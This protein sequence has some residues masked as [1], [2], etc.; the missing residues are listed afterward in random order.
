MFASVLAGERPAASGPTEGASSVARG[1]A[2]LSGRADSR[3]R[4]RRARARQRT[5]S[6]ATD[7][8]PESLAGAAANAIA[9]AASRARREDGSVRRLRHAGL[10]P[11]GNHCRAS[12]LPRGGGA[13]GRLAHG[14]AASHRT[15]RGGGARDAGA[16][17]RRRPRRRKAALCAL[18]QRRRRHPRRPDGDAAHRPPVPRRQ[19]RLQGH[20]HRAP[21]GDDPEALRHRADA[22]ARPARAPG[23][24]GSARCRAPRAVA[25]GIDVHDRRGGDDR[26]HR[27]LRD[28]VGLYRRGRLRDLGRRR[29]RR[30]ARA[31]PARRAGGQARRSRRTRHLAPRS[32][33]VPLR[34]H[35][36]DGDHADRSGARVGDPEGTPGRQR[37]GG[38]PGATTIVHQLAEA[39]RA[40]A[41]FSSSARRCAKARRSSATPE[42]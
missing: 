9:R 39:P 31:R 3:S 16:G 36:I 13:V 24:R 15:R 28:A 35:D 40:S 11:R 19:R 41:S 23:T 32:G 26:R 5:C 27:L 30:S 37:A 8:R 4:I 18:H 10:L 42:S 6:G 17:G 12:P 25:C 2:N 29:R 14:T 38:Y 21:A 33:L 7:V 34:L 1:A 20:R 22:R